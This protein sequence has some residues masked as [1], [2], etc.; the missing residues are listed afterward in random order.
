[1]GRLISSSLVVAQIS[2][3]SGQF[4]Q[5]GLSLSLYIGLVR[6][7]SRI[8]VLALLMGSDGLW[9]SSS[10]PSSWSRQWQPHLSLPYHALQPTSQHRVHHYITFSKQS[11]NNDSIWTDIESYIKSAD[12]GCLVLPSRRSQSHSPRSTVPTIV[13]C[14]HILHL[15][16]ASEFTL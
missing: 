8:T 2:L 1:M 5:W 11:T 6:E 14:S 7:W 4:D 16:H 3:C 15:V 9:W 10:T 13:S 12:I